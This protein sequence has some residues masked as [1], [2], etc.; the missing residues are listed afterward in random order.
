MTT[1]HRPCRYRHRRPHHPPRPR[2]R[3]HRRPSIRPHRRP[4]LR[5]PRRNTFACWVV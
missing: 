4:R 3:P 1:N 5:P 2:I